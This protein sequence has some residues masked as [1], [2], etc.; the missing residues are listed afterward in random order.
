M[1]RVLNK[2]L[3]MFLLALACLSTNYAGSTPPL[4]LLS[5]ETVANMVPNAT[6]TLTYVVKNNVP[7]APVKINIEPNRTMLTP[8]SLYTTW[9]ISDD[10]A[11]NGLRHYVPPNG[12]CNV[13][14]VIKAGRTEAHIQQTLL[15]NYGPTYQII[16]PAPILSFDISRNAAGFFFTVEPSGNNMVI[17]STQTLSWIVKN[18]TTSNITIDNAT[19]NFTIPS[20]LIAPPT[21]TNNCGN[22]VTAGGGICT[23][24]TTIQSL[25]TPGQVIQYLAIPYGVGKTLIADQP[26]NF[27]IYSSLNTRDL[28][29]V[30][31]CP[32][33]V[34]LAFVGGGQLVG[35]ATDA[36]CDSK[37]NVTPGTFACD[38]AAAAGNGICN[39]R[40]PIP[41][42]GNYK[43]LANGGQT[44]V[45]LI[46]NVYPLTATQ[47]LVWSGVIG[48][49]TRC[50]QP[51]GCTTGDCGGGQGG[52]PTGSGLSQP[53]QQAEPTF[54]QESD[55]YDITGI[56]GINIPMSIEPQAVTP[57]ADNP[58][59]CGATGVSYAQP[60]TRGTIG[61]CS[62]NFNPPTQY[63][64]WV[65][66]TPT[67]PAV[68]CTVNSDCVVSGEACGL[69]PDAIA[70][71]SGQTVCG[72]FE[73][74]WTGDQVCGMNPAY[75]HGPFT[76]PSS[77]GT[78]GT[79][80]NMF[81][82][83]GSV[84]GTSCYNVSNSSDCCGCQNWQD[85]PYFIQVPSDQHVVPQ[86]FN[87]GT[88]SSN[89]IWR[90]SALPTLGWYKSACPPFYVYP[91]DDK[92]S[93]FSCNNAQPGQV[94]STGYKIT[95][96]PGGSTGAPVGVT[97][98]P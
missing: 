73:G 29:F 37:P 13:I 23:I 17:N 81:Q 86:C 93:T 9:Q 43:L 60:S 48:G 44:T 61:G 19:I 2:I 25:S 77:A 94:N 21:F 55:F 51:G 47:H 96:C 52:C 34:W 6:Q 12:R 88:F 65:A 7:T 5:Q 8:L 38:P 3:T 45:K 82:C 41:P 76:C 24:T 91:F 85:A 59:T 50:D 63:Y 97:P 22:V 90:S 11:Y 83:T 80:T 54:Q 56:N 74:Y 53:A 14:A 28:N 89:T 27:T 78:G 15:I 68:T 26:V 20:P 35:C 57:A 10:C 58:Y 72:N 75:N 67:P 49:R 39:W 70:A 66:N 36:D 32:Y 4:S 62:W 71:N 69:S 30:N 40:N 33:D 46:E 18:T 87:A 16:S 84:Y 92:S 31:E 1:K 98:N 95:Y 64:V 79:H 42:G